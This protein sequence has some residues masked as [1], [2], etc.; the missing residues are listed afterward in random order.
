MEFYLQRN[1]IRKISKLL[2]KSQT[3]YLR[4]VVHNVDEPQLVMYASSRRLN[5]NVDLQL[6]EFDSGDVQCALEGGRSSIII[7]HANSIP[8]KSTQNYKKMKIERNDCLVG[9]RWRVHVHDVI[10]M[11][12]QSH[13]MH[14]GV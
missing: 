14:A 8:A 12:V 10:Q 4:F 2:Q 13:L 7:K 3:Q 1:N 6:Y 11:L 9:I 5:T